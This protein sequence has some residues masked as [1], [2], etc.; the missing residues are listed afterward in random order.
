VKIEVAPGLAT[1]DVDGE[2][3]VLAAPPIP[4]GVWAEVD[5]G[6]STLEQTLAHTWEEPLW[7]E[8][9]TSVGPPDLVAAV[10]RRLEEDRELLLRWRGFGSDDEAAGAWTGGALPELPPPAR[11]PPNS[12]PKRFGSS[13]VVSA[14]S[15]L[16]EALV[17]VYDAF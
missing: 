3:V 16:V 8:D 11:R 10:R 4:A 13:G 1:A 12:V 15:D 5:A 7:P 2:R 6:S 9:V 17:R 14:G